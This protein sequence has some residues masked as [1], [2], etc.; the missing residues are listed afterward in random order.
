MQTK[1]M[2]AEYLFLSLFFFFF[3]QSHLPDMS[4]SSIQS[5][6]GVKCSDTTSLSLS[7]PKIDGNDLTGLKNYFFVIHVMNVSM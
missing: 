3:F 4:S 1:L 5:A 6:K 2:M 7:T